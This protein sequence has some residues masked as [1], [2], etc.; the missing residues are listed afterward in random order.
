MKKI[1]RYALYEWKIFFRVKIAFFYSIVFPMV[2]LVLYF[3]A[4]FSTE[5]YNAI[6]D[7]FPYLISITLISTAAGLAALI[8]N[9]RLY[10]TWKFFNLY[11]Y[12]TWQMTIASGLIYF[13]ISIVI[14]LLMT[15]VMFF[16]FS[17]ME[18]SLG[19]LLLM[20][21]AISIGTIIYIQIAIITGL[22]VNEP[23]NA[24]TIIN[25]LIYLFVIFSGSIVRFDE[26]SILGR[27]ILL[28]PNIHI[29]NLMHTIWNDSRIDFVS[30]MV[31]TIYCIVFTVLI[32]VII[33]RQQKALLYD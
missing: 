20:L 7:Y 23:R 33:G 3:A 11:G 22:V 32:A 6:N 19:K 13:L 8:V 29:G 30:L 28:F 18:F 1:F 5:N 4:T 2:L 17:A 9:N 21:A 14:S 31:L 26:N 24:Q 27:F 25:G 15:I 16:A 10:N 12:K